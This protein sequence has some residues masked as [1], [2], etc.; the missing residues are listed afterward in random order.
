LFSRSQEFPRTA[1]LA[2]ELLAKTGSNLEKK[3][4]CRE[5]EQ[6]RIYKYTIRTA[7]TRSGKAIALMLLSSSGQAD[8]L[9]RNSDTAM[10]VPRPN[11]TH[12][13]IVPR[14]NT[15]RTAHKKLNRRKKRPQISGERR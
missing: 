6:H 8:L 5:R 12:E 9:P 7:V 3:Q 15:K 13:I 2:V 10:A 4:T 11:S 1:K 14:I